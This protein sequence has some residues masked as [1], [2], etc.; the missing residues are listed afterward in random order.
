TSS[1]RLMAIGSTPF[2]SRYA[3]RGSGSTGVVSAVQTEGINGFPGVT[4]LLIIVS[5]INRFNSRGGNIRP[6]AP[7]LR[8]RIRANRSFPL[9]AL[10]P[11][12]INR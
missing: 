11:G 3:V 10:D 2:I 12:A 1:G 9:K 7:L 8:R 5:A 6:V 4:T